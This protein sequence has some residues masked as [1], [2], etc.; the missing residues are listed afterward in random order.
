MQQSLKIILITFFQHYILWTIVIILLIMIDLI[1]AFV[2]GGLV[3]ISYRLYH[4][5]FKF[6]NSKSQVF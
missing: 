5:I 6:V 1:L 3:Y 4:T 2:K